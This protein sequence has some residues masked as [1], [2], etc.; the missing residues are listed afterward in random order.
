MRVLSRIHQLSAK[1]PRLSGVSI[2]LFA[3]LLG[4]GIGC[5][6]AQD[7]AAPAAQPRAESRSDAK[8]SPDTAGQN[9]VPATAPDLAP[10]L[11]P[12]DNAADQRPALLG[13]LNALGLTG[14]LRSGY[15]SSNRLYDDRGNIGTASTWL[16]LDKRFENGLGVFAEAYGGREDFR[17]DGNGVTRVREAYLDARAGALD[18][19]LGQQIIA[20]GRADRLNPTDNLTPRD[21]RLLAADV[22]EDRFGSLAAKASWNLD[23]HTSLTGVWLPEFRPNRIFLRS[24]F[25]EVI[26]NGSRNWALKLDQSGKAV[27]WSVSYYDGYDLSGDLSASYVFRHYRTRVIGF[28][29]ATT[30]GAW[31]FALESAYTRTE[32]PDGTLAYVKN[33][34]VYTVLGIERDFG[35]NTSGIVQLFNR[36]VMHHQTPSAAEQLHAILTSQ[37]DRDQNGVSVRVAKKWWNE[38]LETEL[39]GSALLE[40]RGYLVRPRLSYAWSDQIK[41]LAGYEYFDGSSNTLYGLLKRNR[42]LFTELRYF[43]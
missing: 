17:S 15:W 13:K 28:D 41:L 29:T 34:F 35:N 4:S 31:R 26:P 6:S 2:C 33:P 40:R 12:P 10:D 42:L 39:S 32:D 1:R 20:W 27:D 9:T 37:L 5:A 3:V 19:R 38:T 11:A 22:D 24:G 21:S 16:K 23:A 18:F 8:E 30:R 14:S 25:S 36:R 43:F 7:A